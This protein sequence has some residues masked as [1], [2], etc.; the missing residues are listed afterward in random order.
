MLYV[1][2]EEFGEE[3]FGIVWAM[4]NNDSTK[5]STSTHLDL[6][7][8]RRTR[9]TILWRRKQS[10][11]EAEEGVLVV[12]GDL[13]ESSRSPSFPASPI[14]SCLHNDMEKHFQN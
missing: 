8:D 9:T 11:E 10:G 6:H 5:I 13:W 1:S 3:G 14:I 2:L 4:G 12:T 7:N